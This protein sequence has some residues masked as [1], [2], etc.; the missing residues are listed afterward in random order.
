[1]H[2]WQGLYLSILQFS[3]P[4]IPQQERKRR[5]AYFEGAWNFSNFCRGLEYDMQIWAQYLQNIYQMHQQY[6]YFFQN[7]AVMVELS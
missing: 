1:M 2:P 3:L 7:T 5:T 6:F 4:Q